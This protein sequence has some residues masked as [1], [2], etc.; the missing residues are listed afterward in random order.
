MLL[1][2]AA[3]T[4][5]VLRLPPL[6]RF[7]VTVVH[8]P[9][10]AVKKGEDRYE[11]TLFLPPHYDV[12]AYSHLE[13]FF[14]FPVYGVATFLTDSISNNIYDIYMHTQHFIGKVLSFQLS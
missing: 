3:C 6:R 9:R 13:I 1:F 8:D 12:P 11:N 2:W 4:V 14:S 5:R 10:M 7:D